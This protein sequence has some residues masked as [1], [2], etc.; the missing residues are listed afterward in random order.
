MH[1]CAIVLRKYLG[2]EYEVSGTIMPGSRLQN[3]TKLATNE[4]G[5][6]SDS[7]AIMIWGGSND[8][9]RNE[10]LKGLKY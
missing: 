10:T 2:P 3:V 8:I 1:G 7:D 4:I 5:G 9:N 6:F